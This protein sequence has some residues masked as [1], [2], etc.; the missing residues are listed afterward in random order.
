ME[1]IIGKARQYWQDYAILGRAH[2]IAWERF[3]R[4]NKLFGVPVVVTST[5]VGTA[6]FGTIQEDPDIR[7]KVAA[8]LLSL[9]AAV[10]SALQTSL[11]Y[12]ELA[13]K[14]KLAGARYAALRRQLDLFM[15]KH[16]DEAASRDRALEEMEA[17]LV[18]VAELAEESPSLPDRVYYAAEKEFSGRN[19][20]GGSAP[21]PPDPRSAEP[22]ARAGQS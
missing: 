8:G 15:L 5:I 3:S 20:P 11:K 21:R 12:A 7:W 19:G 13:E 9:T 10:L 4:R 6:I 16:G 2:Y 18:R 17:L 14:H 22:T 1:E